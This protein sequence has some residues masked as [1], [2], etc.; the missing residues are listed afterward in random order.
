MATAAENSTSLECS[1]SDSVSESFPNDVP[2]TKLGRS[3]PRKKRK[4]P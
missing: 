1:S 3:R 2:E 4:A